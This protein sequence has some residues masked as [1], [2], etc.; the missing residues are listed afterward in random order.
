MTVPDQT[1]CQGLPSLGSLPSLSTLSLTASITSSL[2]DHHHLRHHRGGGGG[3]DFDGCGECDDGG[4]SDCG[5]SEYNNHYRCRRNKEIDSAGSSRISYVDG[6]FLR[7]DSLLSAAQDDDLQDLELVVGELEEAIKQMRIEDEQQESIFPKKTID[8]SKVRSISSSIADS[9]Q[10]WLDSTHKN[11]YNDND[12]DSVHDSN[13]DLGSASAHSHSQLRSPDTETRK[14]NTISCDLTHQSKDNLKQT[15]TYERRS[16]RVSRTIAPPSTLNIQSLN[17]KMPRSI[18]PNSFHSSN[19]AKQ[20]SKLRKMEPKKETADIAPIEKPKKSGLARIKC[21]LTKPI[22]G[23]LT[24][25]SANKTKPSAMAT[26]KAAATTTSVSKSI[27]EKRSPSVGVEASGRNGDNSPSSGDGWSPGYPKHGRPNSETKEVTG[28]GGFSPYHR[29]DSTSSA[30]PV[31]SS[32]GPSK[33]T[34]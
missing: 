27:T 2:N 11:P 8:E 13:E 23:K 20:S 16:L 31:K 18:T 3:D 28:P 17:D 15:N 10:T 21:S 25:N 5:D 29:K 14:R 7:R 26:T 32:S 4:I 9:S 12:Y 6:S 19:Q 34:E 24:A 30:S 1:D 22:T 33:Q